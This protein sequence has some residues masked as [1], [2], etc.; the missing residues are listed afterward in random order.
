MKIKK[1]LLLLF[2][3]V[4]ANNAAAYGSS[5]S[6]KACKKPKFS[7]FTP[8]HLADVA[9]G[10]EFSFIASSITLPGSIQVTV[11]N[12]PVDVVV[13]QKNTQFLIEGQLPAELQGT[14]ARINIQ[15][16]STKKCKGKDGWLLKI[17]D[18]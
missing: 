7:Q 11:K 3:M 12:L 5:S 10:V 2:I 18:N 6:K 13:T 15:A 14:H 9:P 1:F 4:F 8:P 16:S 17:K